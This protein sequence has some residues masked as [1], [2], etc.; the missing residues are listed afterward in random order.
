MAGKGGASGAVESAGT[1]F[2][3]RWPQE[4]AEHGLRLAIFRCWG[5]DRLPIARGVEG[6]WAGSK[7]LMMMELG[8]EVNEKGE[9]VQ[10]RS[11]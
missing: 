10:E 8:G 5:L 9:S 3:I 11:S 6:Q 4:S 1:W 2:M 7:R